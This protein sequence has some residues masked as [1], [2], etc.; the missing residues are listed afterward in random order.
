[1]ASEEQTNPH[2]PE[3]TSGINAQDSM[4][5]PILPQELIFDIISRLPVKS[6]VQ[7]RCVC[8]S[9]L[10]LISNHEFAKTHLKISSEKNRGKPDS[11]AF[12][13]CTEHGVTL[14]SCNLD[15]SMHETKSINAA[16][17]YDDTMIIKTLAPRILE[18][19][20]RGLCLNWLPGSSHLTV[21]LWAQ[22]AVLKVIAPYRIKYSCRFK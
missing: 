6:L 13:R 10:S 15:S 16:E 11:L 17:I 19:I 18:K 5:V 1:M 12:G 20:N 14:H 4:P 3:G 21:H 9:W 22:R 2:I 8:K 7:F